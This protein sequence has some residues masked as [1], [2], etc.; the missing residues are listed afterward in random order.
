[1]RIIASFTATKNRLERWL[2]ATM[3]RATM[4]NL[5]R[6]GNRRISRLDRRPLRLVEVVVFD[7]ALYGPLIDLRRANSKLQITRANTRF[8]RETNSCSCECETMH[9]RS[10]QL[11]ITVVD[12]EQ[13]SFFC[14][15]SMHDFGHLNSSS[16]YLE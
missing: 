12:F 14:F 9:R 1:M 5:Q 15:R 16:A 4:Y 6:R 11:H 10:V 13:K 3:V 2:I 8:L 7:P